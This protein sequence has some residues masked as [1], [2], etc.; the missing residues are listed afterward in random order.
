[1]ALVKYGGGVV[2]ASGSIAGTVHARNRFGN[3]IRARTKPV[4]PNSTG[5]SLM[6]NILAYCAAFWS[7]SC[8]AAERIAWTTYAAA[9]PFKNRLG[10]TI[11]L[12]GFNHFVRYTSLWNLRYGIASGQAPTDLSLPG[13][14]PTFSVVASVATGLSVSF[15]VGLPWWAIAQ[16]QIVVFMGQPQNK[17]RNFF[18][19]PWKLAGS[20]TTGEA[21]PK[22]IAPPF[23]LT[24]G[25][26]I[27]IYGRIMTGPGNRRLSEPM[28]A[29]T[30]VV[31]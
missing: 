4:N 18:N 21:S 5:Q 16:S 15:D 3:Y 10:E 29:S 11:Y 27:W 13:K 12:T 9:V 22:V 20:A 2:G 7:A 6:R 14:D 25:Q 8:T 1:M 31:A 24:L 23:T 26:K 19:G 28:V 17:T 30:I